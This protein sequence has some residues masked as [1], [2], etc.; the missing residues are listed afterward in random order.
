MLRVIAK[1]TLRLFWENHK[2]CE[3]QVKTWYNEISKAFWNSLNELK[4]DYPSTSILENSRVVFN[5]KCNNYR[6]IVKISYEYQIIW[7]KFIGSH[8]EYDKTE[9]VKS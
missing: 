7:I 6:L 4:N 2:D 8:V 1:K 9:L 5:I 3:E